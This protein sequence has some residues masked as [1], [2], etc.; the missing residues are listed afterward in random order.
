[1]SALPVISMGNCCCLWLIG[2]GALAAWLLQQDQ[3]TPVTPGQGAIAGL[4]AGAIGAFVWLLGALVFD[5]LMGPLM[6]GALERALESTA[7]MRPEV[8]EAMEMIGETGNPFR[9]VAGLIFQ[10]FAGIIFSTLGGLL[11]A[12]FLSR[13]DLPPAH[14]GPPP[15]P[16]QP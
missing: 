4:L 14:G 15:L 9:Y 10:F 7:E 1:M 13:E 16:P 5:A 2:G 3:P 8:R 12:L 6:A 11:G